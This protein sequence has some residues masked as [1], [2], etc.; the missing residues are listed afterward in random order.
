MNWRWPRRTS[1]VAS[2]MSEGTLW[3]PQ[4]A[5]R[6]LRG[7]GGAPA[8]GLA[9]RWVAYRPPLSLNLNPFSGTP[10]NDQ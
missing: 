6:Q 10:Q 5:S 4:T 1:R 8:T 7:F 9:A 3:D 2:S